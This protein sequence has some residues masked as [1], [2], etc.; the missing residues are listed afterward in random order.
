VDPSFALYL[1]RP[2]G[3]RYRPAPPPDAPLVLEARALARR[4]E[5]WSGKERT[6]RFNNLREQF[7]LNQE[8]A[9][10]RDAETLEAPASWPTAITEL[11]VQALLTALAQRSGTRNATA[12]AV[13]LAGTRA[14][15]RRAARRRA[16]RRL[17]LTLDNA[18]RP[19]HPAFTTFLAMLAL[20]AFPRFRAG[21]FPVIPLWPF[22]LAVG[23]VRELEERRSWRQA[24]RTSTARPASS[25]S[26]AASDTAAAA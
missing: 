13:S 8:Y 18:P 5:P 22:W 20:K 19:V 1:V 6:E 26:T 4:E 2:I 23:I 24:W 9:L 3:R 17:G 7:V 21:W 16:A 25:D 14:G 10:A 11:A 12:V 15:L